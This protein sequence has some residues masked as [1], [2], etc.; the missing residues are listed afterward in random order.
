VNEKAGDEVKVEEAAGGDT[1]VALLRVDER[2]AERGGEEDGER[3][4]SGE[5]RVRV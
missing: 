2:T 1:K 5:K 4:A 3:L